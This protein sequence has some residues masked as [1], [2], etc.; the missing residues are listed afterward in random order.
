LG[1]FWKPLI[2]LIATDDADSSRYVKLADEPKQAVEMI[3]DK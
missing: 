3:I 2:E 1:G